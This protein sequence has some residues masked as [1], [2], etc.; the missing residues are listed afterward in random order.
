MGIL[1]GVWRRSQTQWGWP[2]P[3][4][5]TPKP[6]AQLYRGLCWG[7]SSEENEPFHLQAQLPG[8]QVTSVQSSVS[9]A[10]SLTL[11]LGVTGATSLLLHS[12]GDDHSSGFFQTGLSLISRS[13]LQGSSWIRT[14]PCPTNNPLFIEDLQCSRCHT[15]C[16]KYLIWC[17]PHSIT[18]KWE[19]S[20]FTA[21]DTETLE[22]LSCSQWRVK[23]V[24][25]T[26]LCLRSWTPQVLSFLSSCLWSISWIPRYPRPWPKQTGYPE[27][28]SAGPS[29]L[30]GHLGRPRE[31]G[32][33]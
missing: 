5:C 13:A 29:H 27:P 11:L 8:T 15:R 1:A 31:P 26:W 20:H 9:P 16:F 24:I 28:L 21:V 6:K 23:L 32:S 12:S 30:E 17:H 7:P 14:L 4:T 19:L 25:Q 3:L 2:R 18:L 10:Q 33:S 22:K